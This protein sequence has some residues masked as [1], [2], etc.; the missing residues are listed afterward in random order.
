MPSPFPGMD[1]YL[2]RFWPGVHRGL[3]TYLI[4]ELNGRL[5]PPDL[6]ADVTK[7]ALVSSPDGSC[8]ARLLPHVYVIESPAP[9]GRAA[10]AEPVIVQLPDDPVVETAVH[11]T[12]LAGATLITAV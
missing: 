11:I 1:P 10:V 12:D 9:A 6:R 4:D 8:R 3:V 5:L 2:V 7:R